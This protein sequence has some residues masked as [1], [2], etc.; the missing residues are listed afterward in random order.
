MTAPAFMWLTWQ[1]YVYTYV[2]HIQI[3]L[4][5]DGNNNAIMLRTF[6]YVYIRICI[7][8]I[9]TSYM[10]LRSTKLKEFNTT[11]RN[12][13]AYTEKEICTII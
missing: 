4:N 12:C 7:T 6:D 10:L 5:N 1:C 11:Y 3:K 8:K 13:I 2:D 9:L